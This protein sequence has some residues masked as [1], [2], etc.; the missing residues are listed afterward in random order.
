M[1]DLFAQA[2]LAAA[3]GWSNKHEDRGI[4]TK[5][6]ERDDDDIGSDEDDEWGDSV[7]N[8]RAFAVLQHVVRLPCGDVHLCT[9]HC[10]YTT[11]TRD[12]QCVCKYS[13]LVV[14]QAHA[15]RTDF[16]TGR[17]TWSSD[18]DISAGV[19]QGS[20]H[21][22]RD[23]LKASRSAF[24]YANTLDDRE[25]PTATP[26]DSQKTRGVVKRGAMCVVVDENDPQPDS[27]RQRVGRRNG[28]SSDGRVALHGEACRIFQELVG[29]S[30]T[31]SKE[32]RV[33]DPRLL[34][35]DLLFNASLKKFLKDVVAVGGHPTLDDVHNISLAVT[36]V[37]EAEQA[38]RAV[39]NTTD[40]RERVHSMIF[41]EDGARL[42]V[43]L[44]TAACNTPY[45]EQ[46][47]RGADSFRPFCAGVFYSFKRGLTLADG[48]VL[49]PK[50]DGFSSALPS[51]KTISSDPVSKSVHAA[52]HRGLCTLH[53]V[54]A[55]VTD[56]VEAHRIFG[57]AARVAAHF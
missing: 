33:V 1:D 51:A 44:W 32:D 42:T 41:K 40:V 55:S 8:K 15:D 4:G 11:E 45:L 48:T 25:M 10:P 54:I 3:G 27:K 52:S 57:E 20:W 53:R 43:A 56:P 39:T 19:S 7:I 2:D 29:R 14:A 21:K 36:R 17:S 49:V 28:G 5:R 12:G 37:I 47:R 22:R 23:M 9:E 35:H 38:K 18:P 34:D 50:I 31:A 24:D 13:G 6:G 30:H 26:R 46:A 16:S